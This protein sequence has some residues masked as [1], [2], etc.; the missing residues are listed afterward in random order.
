MILYAST[1]PGWWPYQLVSLANRRLPPR[2]KPG[3][4]HILVD[5]GMFGFYKRGERPALDR[6]YA[7]LLRFVHDVRR[8]RQPA[9]IV[10]VLPDWLNDPGFTVEAARHPAARRLCRD[11]RCAAVA[12]GS[13][14]GG[15][16]SYAATAEDLAALDHV[17][18]IAAPLK[19]NCSRLVS[20]R[21]VIR[22][23]CQLAVAEQACTA[24]KNHGLWCHGLG[25]GL[26]ARHVERLARLGMDSIDTSSWTRPVNSAVARTGRWSAKTSREREEYFRA[27]L[28]ALGLRVPPAGGR[29]KTG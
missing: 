16:R 4:Y 9:E 24:A 5:N 29:G 15:W 20:G 22:H 10:V 8:L 23:E 17:A 7:M 14:T 18:W 26:R 21:R 11:Y 19:L 28:E 12:H 1:A 2:Q 3:F 13:P 25:A 6:W 27:V